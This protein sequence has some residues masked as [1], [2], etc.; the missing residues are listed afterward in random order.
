MLVTSTGPRRGSDGG[1][2][3]RGVPLDGRLR[4]RGGG[5]ENSSIPATTLDR[6]ERAFAMVNALLSR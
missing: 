5:Y 4:G 3:S 2:P 6:F 1:I